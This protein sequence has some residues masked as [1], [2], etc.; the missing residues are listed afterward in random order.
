MTA[1]YGSV[2]LSVLGVLSRSIRM[3]GFFQAEEDC[4]FEGPSLELGEVHH[5][6]A[7]QIRGEDDPAP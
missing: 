3:C 7:A 6:W 4:R 1:W 5:L 2:S